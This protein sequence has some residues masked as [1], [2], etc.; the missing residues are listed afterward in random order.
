MGLLNNV[1]VSADC[2]D[3]T[4]YMKLIYFPSKRDTLSNGYMEYLDAAEAEH[5]TI[6]RKRELVEV[7]DP[8]KLG[9]EMVQD[10]T[11]QIDKR[12]RLNQ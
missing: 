1:I 6:Y 11:K 3:F 9:F 2:D 8:S 4:S 7:V 10:I 5:R 12:I